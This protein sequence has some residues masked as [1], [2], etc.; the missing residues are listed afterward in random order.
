MGL[1]APLLLCTGCGLKSDPIHPKIKLPAA[2]ADLTVE[3]LREGILLAWSV[4]PLDKIG[5]FRLLRSE[6]VRGS[7]ACPGCPQ[8]YLPLRAI[9][10]TDAG[11]RSERGKK[12]YYIDWDVSSG[13]FYSYRIAAC[14]RSGRCGALS[15]E[16]GAIHA[17]K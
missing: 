8:T 15:N 1:V 14:D 7:D 12:F 9:P 16:A 10:L 5:S 13:F 6:P 17:G 2:V 3:S 4:D 11:L